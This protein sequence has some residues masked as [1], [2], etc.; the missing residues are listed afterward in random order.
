M[1]QAPTDLDSKLGTYFRMNPEVKPFIAPPN[2]LEGQR[3]LITR[4]RTGSLSLAIELARFSKIPCER[5]V[6]VWS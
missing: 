6:Q 3:K 4:F 2:I 1:V 5:R